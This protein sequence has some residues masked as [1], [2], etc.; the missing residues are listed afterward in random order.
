VQAVL[1]ECLE[2]ADGCRVAQAFGDDGF[3]SGTRAGHID[4]LGLRIVFLEIG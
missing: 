2:T 4:L 3:H 1:L